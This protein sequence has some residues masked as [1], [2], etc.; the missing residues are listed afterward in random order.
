MAILDWRAAS[1]GG[2]FTPFDQYYLSLKPSFHARHASF[3]EIEELL[4][5]RGMTPDLFYGRFE[6]DAE[7]RLVPKPGLR[8]CLSVYGD[9][10]NFDVNTASPALM[11]GVGVGPAAIAGLLAYRAAQPIKSMND[12]AALNDGSPGF[13][14][15]GLS[16]SPVVTLR[17][18]AHLRLPNGQFSDV[19]RSV[20]AVIGFLKPENNPSYAILRWYDN[21]WSAQ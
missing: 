18:T 7:D 1:E 8:D 12:I 17:S 19:R 21:A 14:R 6:P 16:V 4:L 2:S 20:S 11:R 15:L 9:V 5:V 3:E 13:S 10:A